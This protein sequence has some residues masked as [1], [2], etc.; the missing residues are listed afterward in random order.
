MSYILDALKKADGERKA[1]TSAT[2]AVQYTFSQPMVS[3]AAHRYWNWVGGGIAILAVIGMGFM[4]SY[5]VRSQ[6]VPEHAPLITRPELSSIE[7][8]PETAVSTLPVMPA[9][10]TPAVTPAPVMQASIEEAIPAR[11]DVHVFA[12]TPSKRFVIVNGTQYQIGEKLPSGAQLVDITQ[13]GAVFS[14]QGQQST[15][16]VPK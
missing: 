8:V 3:M 12:A 15:V 6:A 5:I 13:V 4:V 10:S 11:L 14:F 16:A 1:N 2:V 9:I 7:P